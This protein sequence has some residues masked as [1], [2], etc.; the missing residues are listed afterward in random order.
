MSKIQPAFLDSSQLALLG[1]PDPLRG[2]RVT[3]VL[4]PELQS[5]HID[6]K[7]ALQS[8]SGPTAPSLRAVRLLQINVWPTRSNGKLNLKGLLEEIPKGRPIPRGALEDQ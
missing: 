4:G 7:G 3:L 1:R 8:L 6:V 2:E 5:R